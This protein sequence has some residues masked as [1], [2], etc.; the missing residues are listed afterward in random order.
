MHYNFPFFV[1]E[2]NKKKK[3][4]LVDASDVDESNTL[5][6]RLPFLS[7]CLFKLFYTIPRFLSLNTSIKNK[8]FGGC[9]SCRNCSCKN[10]TSITRLPFLSVFLSEYSL[11]YFS[12]LKHKK[13]NL[14]D[15]S[16]GI[17]ATHQYH[18]CPFLSSFLSNDS[19]LNNFPC[20][21]LNTHRN[22]QWSGCE[23]CRNCKRKNNASITRL[24]FLPSF[25]IILRILYNTPFFSEHKH[26]EDNLMNVRGGDVRITQQ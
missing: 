19:I 12:E 1:S 16:V 20:L 13:G 15:A 9:K 10:N 21:S 11:H 2:H 18:V 7:L 24:P 23:S 5:V 14:V 8:Q 3:N 22:K 25:Q 4:S 6:T 17:R 26:K